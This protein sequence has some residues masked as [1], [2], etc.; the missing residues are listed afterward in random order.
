MINIRIHNLIAKISLRLNVLRS[1]WLS[2]LFLKCPR[3]V[4][5]EK[6][7]LLRA[8]DRISIG[9]HCRFHDYIYL[10]VWGENKQDVVISIGKN[11][12]FGA[13]NNITGTNYIEI[14]N[15]CLTGKWVTISDN[16]H[17]STEIEVLDTPPIKR[18]ICSKGPIIIG[19]NVWIGEK[20]TILSG[21]TIGKG[22]VIG[23]NSVVTR[24]VPPYAVVAGNPAKIIK[25]NNICN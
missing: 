22:A 6:I 3:S 18:T 8:T 21:V 9:D 2:T 17:G 13:F 16:N 19:D 11:C 24:D 25:R 12:N 4:Y 5:F 20:T 1:H 10:T 7:G 14:G 23:A 15:N